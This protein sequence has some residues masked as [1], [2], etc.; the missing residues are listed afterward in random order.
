[1]AKPPP[2][3]ARVFRGPRVESA[4]RGSA[5]VV[6]ERGA[7]LAS[8]GAPRLAFSARSAA[9]PFQ[10][11]PLLLAGGEKRFRLSDA[12]IAL[13]CASH[14]GEPRHTAGGGEPLPKGGL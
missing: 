1:M 13:L 4:H 3:L 6:D 11:M 5:A 9:K 14:G 12:E 2:I 7:L 10:A 8:C